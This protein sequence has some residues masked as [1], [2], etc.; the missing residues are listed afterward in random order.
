KM[1][2]YE[3]SDQQLYFLFRTGETTKNDLVLI[4][5]SYDGKEVERYNV[6]PELDFRLTHFI[7]V[8]S[9]FIFGGYVSN[10][11]V[12]VL[13]EPESNNLKVIPGFFQKDTE[14][15]DLRTNLNKTFNTVLIDRTSRGE[16]KV[17][18]RTFDQNG[19]Q[20]LEDIVPIEENITLQTGITS[21]LKR[22][23]L[24]IAGTWGD[25]NSKQ[26]LGFYTLTID[27]F[28]NQ[29]I[30]FIDFGR[31][32]H[33]VDYLNT[34]RADRIKATAE[35]NAAAGKTASFTSYVMP[36]RIEESDK[37][38]YLLAEVYSPS[39]NS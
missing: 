12:I 10:E 21:T 6:K 14:L 28:S 20:L 29:K 23:D 19:K 17:V 34:K 1:M 16:K 33:F 18:L 39:G 8:G 35:A 26:S 25:R 30:Q 24:I 9:N 7:K 11:A 27:P 37:G 22:E 2:G 32:D 38:F 15:V 31:L 3:V 5:I 4:E 36:F 13:F